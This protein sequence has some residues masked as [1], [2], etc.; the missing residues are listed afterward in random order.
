ML[1]SVIIPVY[2]E[3]YTLGS[4]LVTVARALPTVS[5]EIIIVDDCSKD[6][7]REW[8]K[9]NFPNGQRSG[10][11]VTLDGNGNL[12]FTN[13]SGASAVTISPIYH[14]RNRG[15]GGSLQTGF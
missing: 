3:R 7:T 2:N 10:S 14:E 15:K 8:L 11:T 1:L 13:T 12:S 5:K 6:G 9:A 4:V